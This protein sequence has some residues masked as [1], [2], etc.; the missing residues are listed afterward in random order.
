MCFLG[1]AALIHQTPPARRLERRFGWNSVSQFGFVLL[2]E[3]C[4]SGG[5]F[6]GD[7]EEVI[8]GIIRAG[9]GAC[10]ITFPMVIDAVHVGHVGPRDFH[11]LEKDFRGE[12]LVAKG[13]AN[14]RRHFFGQLCKGQ[15]FIA[16]TVRL[17]GMPA[18]MGECVGGHLCDVFNVDPS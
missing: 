5:L 14:D 2:D 8:K 18:G 12:R 16:E 6:A 4:P 11:G 17:A 15:S 10:C 9:D 3:G 13:L 1:Q 7:G